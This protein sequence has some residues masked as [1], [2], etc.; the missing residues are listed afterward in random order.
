[1]TRLTATGELGYPWDIRRE[2]AGTVVASGSII[3][4]L[5]IDGACI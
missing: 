4:C 3:I 5:N 1:V 2:K